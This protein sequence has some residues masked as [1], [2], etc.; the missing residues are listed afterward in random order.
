MNISNNYKRIDLLLAKFL[1]AN[2]SG[3]PLVSYN[4]QKPVLTGIVS[5]GI[6]PCG[7]PG[8][9]SVYTR[10][11]KFND[12]IAQKIES[13]FQLNFYINRE[14][15]KRIDVYEKNGISHAVYASKTHLFYKELPQRKELSYE[16]ENFGRIKSTHSSGIRDLTAI[17]NTIY[18][19]SMDPNVKSWMFTNTGLVYQRTY[20]LP[21]SDRFS[22]L[23]SP[24]MSSCPGPRR[25][26]F[27]TGLDC[28]TI[29]VFDSRFRNNPISHYR[30]HTRDVNSLAMNA[31]YILSTSLDKTVSVWDQRAGRTM[32]SITFPGEA[33]F[34]TCINMRQDLVFVGTR[35]WD[36]SRSWDF[37]KLH[38]LNPKDDFK[39]V[40]SYS[41]EHTKS[42]T[43]VHLTHECLITSSED[44]TVRIASLTDPPKPIAT[45]RSEIGGINDMDYL[46]GTLAVVGSGI[47]VWCPK[48]TC[49]TKRVQRNN[50]K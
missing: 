29:Y 50:N 44:G 32:K 39:L 46:N 24:C 23:W 17:D 22:S 31:E 26:L 15:E 4:G 47:K 34:P 7:T 14:T 2:D 20:D 43:K 16:I 33:H 12:W 9:P 11:Y 40:K 3:G 37:P 1:L 42:I 21:R 8:T 25:D 10:V 18:S 13:I 30:P 6:I 41:T 28:G 35:T 48:L 27:A 5:W 19:C 49:S 38:V 36:K 45:L